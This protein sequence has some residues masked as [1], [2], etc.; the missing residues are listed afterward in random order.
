MHIY[1][2]TNDITG[3]TYVGQTIHCPSSR[4]RIHLIELNK[5]NHHCEKLQ[6][7]WLQHTA[8]NFSFR[9]V[10]EGKDRSELFALE[11]ELIDTLPNVYNS[12]YNKDY[13]RPSVKKGPNY[14]YGK[15]TLGDIKEIRRL[16]PTHTLKRL[17]E[18]YG[19][20][21]CAISKLLSGKSYSWIEN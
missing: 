3:Q 20:S 14:K 10:L 1:T 16:R 13:V 4:W 12:T 18:L 21:H 15:L 8:A 2:I 7:D 19:V 5:G 9:V 17:A 6:N 11:K